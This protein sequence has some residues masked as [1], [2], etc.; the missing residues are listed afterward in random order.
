MRY[1]MNASQMNVIRSIDNTLKEILVELK[2]S[3]EPKE[4]VINTSALGEAFAALDK[5]A[6]SKA[7]RMTIYGG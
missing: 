4:A 2:K 5:H 7:G 1:R 6:K 3:S